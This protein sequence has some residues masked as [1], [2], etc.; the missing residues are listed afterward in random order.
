M[1]KTLY[2]IF[3]NV[4]NFVD[5][6][7]PTMPHSITSSNAKNF[8]HNNIKCGQFC[9]F[10]YCATM[11][12]SRAYTMHVSEPSLVLFLGTSI[13]STWKI[14]GDWSS[15]GL[16]FKGPGQ[17][18]KIFNW[19][20]KFYL[21]ILKNWPTSQQKHAGDL[22]IPNNLPLRTIRKARKTFKKSV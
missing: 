21:V 12:Y 20:Q 1:P 15:A 16:T 3:S 8:K 19:Y 18:Y 9:G 5:C 17:K 4:D 6:Y 7:C 22:Y 11:T 2:L 10:C 14:Y 13:K